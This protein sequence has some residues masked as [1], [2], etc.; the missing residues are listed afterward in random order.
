MEVYYFNES[1]GESQWD[2]PLI[3]ESTDALQVRRDIPF[4]DVYLRYLDVVLYLSLTFI[5]V[6]LTSM[7]HSFIL[8]NPRF[9]LSYAFLIMSISVDL[10]FFITISFTLLPLLSYFS[11]SSSP[12][13]LLTSSPS[14]FQPSSSHAKAHKQLLPEG[15]TIM[16]DRTT[17]SNYY[18]NRN[19]GESTYVIDPIL[20]LS[21]FHPNPILAIS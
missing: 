14:S 15:W 2:P 3:V 19:T 18:Y 11:S 7:P 16:Q 20:T 9:I 8:A 17:H 13:H 6:T 1:T 12:P 10:L 4:L 21:Q 5:N